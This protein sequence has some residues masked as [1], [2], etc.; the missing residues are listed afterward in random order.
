MNQTMLSP[1]PERAEAHD[2][3]SPLAPGRTAFVADGAEV[4]TDQPALATP[5]ATSQGTA[6]PAPFQ[7]K[8][9]RAFGADLSSV[10]VHQGGEA[11]QL[12]ARA[13]AHGE[14][15]FF[16]QGR[17][18]PE[19]HQGQELIGHE[20]AHV[21]QQRAG[22]ASVPQGKDAPINVDPALEAAADL[23]GDRAARGEL[24]G[25]PSGTGGARVIQAMFEE[26]ETYK[27][28][29]SV[30][31]LTGS[32]KKTKPRKLTGRVVGVGED[33]K[34][35]YLVYSYDLG[36]TVTVD[37]DDADTTNFKVVSPKEGQDGY[38][39]PI[40]AL[41]Q[42]DLFLNRGNKQ[43]RMDTEVKDK[44]K[45][46][47][48]DKKRIPDKG[49]PGQHFDPS[50]IASK[51]VG[52]ERVQLMNEAAQHG[53]LIEVDVVDPRTGEETKKLHGLDNY[54]LEWFP[55][56]TMDSDHVFPQKDLAPWGKDLASLAS[57]NDGNAMR[58]KREVENT[59]KPFDEMFL[60]DAKTDEYKFSEEGAQAL[61]ANTNNL[62]FTNK[63]TNQQ[64]K[65]DDEAEDF[66]GKS[67]AHGTDF[68]STLPAHDEKQP[69]LPDGSMLAQHVKRENRAPGPNKDA[70]ERN[71][72]VHL[73]HIKKQNRSIRILKDEK[74]A[75]SAK[76]T[77]KAAKEAKGRAQKRKR[78]HETLKTA[79]ELLDANYESEN[80]DHPDEKDAVLGKG[81]PFLFQQVENGKEYD[82]EKQF[83]LVDDQ[84]KELE[85]TKKKLD[86]EEEAHKNT[87]VRVSDLEQTIK[88]KDSEIEKLKKEI[89]QLKNDAKKHTS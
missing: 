52:T 9:E 19:S 76:S 1:A 88:D 25:T 33:D 56:A 77:P 42:H 10:R 83:K 87:K 63:V 2:E 68:L 39:P 29:G 54:T 69:F 64:D 8:M 36:E 61:Y 18:D 5:T 70:A 21:M 35:N 31:E 30:R 20:L 24:A 41:N 49:K 44:H 58:V 13:Y 47:P 59:G 48:V 53:E 28:I 71:K 81:L 65:N 55:M 57:E 74:V 17:F 23:A 80:E 38:V 79:E 11:E 51:K 89:E 40:G 84:K 75:Q 46:F 37:A 43:E 50:L 3:I 15:L 66:L 62:V 22:L 73:Q 12:G 6:L 86:A 72:G 78:K 4:H 14:D 16:A 60:Q 45:F 32:K 82:V 67:L 34:G 85:E 27:V 26:G 7:S